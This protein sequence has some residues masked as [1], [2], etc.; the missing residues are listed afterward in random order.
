MGHCIWLILK[1]LYISMRAFI[2]VAGYRLF[3]LV[4]MT[5]MTHKIQLTPARLFSSLENAKSFM[6]HMGHSKLYDPNDPK[7]CLFVSR[8]CLF[9]AGLLTYRK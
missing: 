5:H 7:A 6:G 1:I 9:V 8:A 4:Q 2:P 3:W